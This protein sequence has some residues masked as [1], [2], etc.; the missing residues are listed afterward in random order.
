MKKKLY[1]ISLVL[2]F[3]LYM[4]ACDSAKDNGVNKPLEDATTTPLVPLEWPESELAR[5]IPVL[6][7]VYGHVYWNRDDEVCIQLNEFTKDQYEAYIASCAAA[8]FD[9]VISEDDDEYCANNADGYRLSLKYLAA[10]TTIKVKTPVLKIDFEIDCETNLIFSTYDLIILFENEELGTIEHGKTGI[11]DVEIDSKGTYTLEIQSATDSSVNTKLDVKISRSGSYKYTVSCHS[12]EIEVSEV[13]K[14]TAPVVPMELGS[15]L[16]NDVKTL[17]TNEGFTNVKT[18]EIK[19]LPIAEVDKAKLVSSITID[20]VS[21]FT[22]EDSFF[23]DASVVITYRTPAKIKMVKSS[24]DY[25]GMNYLDVKKE[26][27]EL[28]FV[29]VEIKEKH[30]VTAYHVTGEVSNVN[31]YSMFKFEKGEEYEYD[32]AITIKYYVVTEPTP[33]PTNTST[34]T[35]GPTFYSTNPYDVAKEGNTGV[36]SYKSKSGTYDVYWI[37]NFDEG[38]VY[39]FTDGNGENFCDKL[40]IEDGTLNDRIT[41]TWHI[42]GEETSWYLHFKNENSPVTL[43]VNDHNGFE[44]EFGTTDLDDALKLRNTKN[45]KEY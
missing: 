3:I 21:D 27:E 7:S 23:A 40:K 20:G 10:Y 8:G 13:G 37:I 31:V 30:E 2:M 28:G 26:L 14:L 32:E 24:E 22:N 35:P 17:F 34:P 16:F 38:Y 19:D 18:E 45:I 33:A 44:T 29:N 9:A 42:D 4:G 1:L 41:I 43:I 11:F 36:F 25:E 12:S 6:D 15:Q 5:M 39:W